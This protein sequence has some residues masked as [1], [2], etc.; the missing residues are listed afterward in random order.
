MKKVLKIMMFLVI[1]VLGLQVCVYADMGAPMIRP[2]NAKVI[3]PDGVICRD[4]QG[5]VVAELKYGDEIRIYHMKQHGKM[6][7]MHHLN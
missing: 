1:L 7:H 6:N 2:Y 5:N 3:N 4:H